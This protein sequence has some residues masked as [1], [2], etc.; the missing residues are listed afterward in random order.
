MKTIFTLV[1]CLI[2]SF[3]CIPS[4]VLAENMI[5]GVIIEQ[6]ADKEFIQVNDSIYQV[7]NVWRD[8]GA[9]DP[10]YITRGYLRMGS[11]VQIYPGVQN[12]D[13]WQTEKVVLLSNGK[14]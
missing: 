4:F 1:I 12:V 13:Y 2:F 6:S 7:E 10:I 8:N 5:T 11:T 9:D 14:D 3:F